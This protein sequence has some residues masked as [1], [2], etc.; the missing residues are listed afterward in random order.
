M[1]V[2]AA[3]VKLMWLLGQGLTGRALRAAFAVDLAGEH[4]AVHARAHDTQGLNDG[5]PAPDQNLGHKTKFRC[6]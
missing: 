5:D 3:T 6:C 2:E 1:T 4:L